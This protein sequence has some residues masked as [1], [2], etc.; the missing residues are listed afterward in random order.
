MKMQFVLGNEGRKGLVK[1]V[2][3]ILEVEARYLGAPGFCYD[4]GGC[5]IGKEIIY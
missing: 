3:G 5:I 2:S 1:A 4:V